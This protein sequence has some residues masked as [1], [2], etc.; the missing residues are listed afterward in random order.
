MPLQEYE[1]KGGKNGQDQFVT[2]KAGGANLGE[3]GKSNMDLLVPPALAIFL[4]A[5]LA[6][7]SK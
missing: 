7:N 6:V 5:K 2:G 1:S 4:W 3:A